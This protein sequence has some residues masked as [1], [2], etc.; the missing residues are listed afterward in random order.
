MGSAMNAMK[1]MGKVAEGVFA[2]N[3]KA[4]L[5]MGSVGVPPTPAM[6]MIATAGDA[7]QLA[8]SAKKIAE[9]GPAPNSAWGNALLSGGK[10]AMSLFG[11]AL[12][13]GGGAG[14]AGMA[15]DQALAMG[16]A[17]L[18]QGSAGTV[19]SVFN[20]LTGLGGGPEEEAAA[21]APA[22]MAPE[23]E[24]QAPEAP[25]PLPAPTPQVAAP[26]AREFPDSPLATDDEVRERLLR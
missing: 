25:A 9:P 13:P 26:P 16:D 22:V 8:K 23:P 17:M 3:D 2:A 1:K 20:Q 15:I 6:G 10:L 11:E 19:G 14:M 24:P 4:S 5:E 18:P 7:V 12:L 21:G